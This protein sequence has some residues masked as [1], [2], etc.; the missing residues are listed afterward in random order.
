MNCSPV[1]LTLFTPYLV[2]SHIKKLDVATQI[3]SD[4]VAN[5]FTIVKDIVIRSYDTK[6][7]SEIWIG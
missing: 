3:N 2:K 4:A 6:K 5:L 7:V 1:H